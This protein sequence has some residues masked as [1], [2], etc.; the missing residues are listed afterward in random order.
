VFGSWLEVAAFAGRLIVA[1]AL[2]GVG[3][4]VILSPIVA[5][6]YVLWRH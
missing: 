5:M 6:I 1:L 3:A 4:A 2:L